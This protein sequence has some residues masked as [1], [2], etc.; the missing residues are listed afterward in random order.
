VTEEMNLYEICIT[1]CSKL[2]KTKDRSTDQVSDVLYAE[3]L[4]VASCVVIPASF[5]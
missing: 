2:L 3:R 1:S 5:Q 4:A